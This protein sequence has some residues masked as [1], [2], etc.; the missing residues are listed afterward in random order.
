[1]QRE[2]RQHQNAN[3]LHRRAGEH[4]RAP[5]APVRGRSGDEGQ[6]EQ[7]HKLHQAYHAHQERALLD[8]PRM[9]RDGVDL[10]ADRDLSLIHI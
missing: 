9:P 5:V 4:D 8:G 2:S 6:Q 10:P 1:M 3:D 7:R